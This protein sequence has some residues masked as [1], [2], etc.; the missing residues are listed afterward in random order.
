MSHP[1]VDL[2]ENELKIFQVVKNQFPHLFPQN[3]I[4]Y[5]I[6]FFGDIR[7]AEVLTLALNPAWTEFNTPRQWLGNFDSPALTTRLI[8]YFD[9]P[10]PEPH[11]WFD[12]LEKALLYIG[13]SY[14]QDAAHVDLLSFPT[15][16]LNSLPPGGR[17][18][19][20]NLVM[21][22]GPRLRSVLALAA[23]AKLFLIVDFQFNGGDGQ[24]FGVRNIFSERVCNF[25]EGANSQGSG[26]QVISSGNPELLAE[27]VFRERFLLRN[28]LQ[29]YSSCH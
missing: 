7:C 23:R 26:S 29:R 5:P 24:H 28:F 25:P 15:L 3:Q 14:R 4:L 1:I 27:S 10:Q 21:Q 22:H 17:T 11:P 8:H 2:V 18:D 6:P 13:C 19:F 16:F 9:L 20:A 12:R